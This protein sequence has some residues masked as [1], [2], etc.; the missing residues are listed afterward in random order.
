MSSHWDDLLSIFDDIDSNSE[1]RRSITRTFLPRMAQSGLSGAKSLSLFQEHNVGIRT[2]DFYSILSDIRYDENVTRDLFELEP[3][4]KITRD[5][6]L[7]SAYGLRGDIYQHVFS[8]GIVDDDGKFLEERN[9]GFTTRDLL[10]KQEAE[11]IALEEIIGR[12][13][14]TSAHIHGLTLRMTFTDETIT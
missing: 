10:S 12:Y 1:Q 2:S 14:T 4:E 3:T 9:Y 8:Y 6:T 5:Y 11:E 13:P 7:R